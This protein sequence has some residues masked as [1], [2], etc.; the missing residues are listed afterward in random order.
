MPKLNTG[1]PKAFSVT[2]TCDAV[3][4]P[5]QPEAMALMVD[6][7]FQEAAKRTSPVAGLM[8]LP[9]EVLAASRL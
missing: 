8:L 2:I 9:P 5:P 3:V 4:G 1:V 6:V 7:P